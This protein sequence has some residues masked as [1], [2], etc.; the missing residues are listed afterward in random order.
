MNSVA[1]QDK[2]AP[3]V[4]CS[5]LDNFVQIFQLIRPRRPDIRHGEVEIY[6]DSVF[7]TGACGG[8][9]IVHLDF[10]ERYDLS[11]R[12][13]AAREAGRDEVAAKL[14]ENRNRIGI[15]LADVSGHR[16]TDALV[17]AMLHQSFLTGVLYELDRFGEVTTRLFEHL[18]TR[19]SRSLSIEKYITVIYG[20][21]GRTGKFRFLSAG[22]PEPLIFSAEYD[23]LVNISPERLVSFYPLGMFPS[24]DHPDVSRHL[25]ALRYKPSYTVNEV[26]LMAVG[27][28][29]LLATDGLVDHERDDDKPFV[30]TELERILRSV[31]HRTA[32]EIYHAIIDRARSFADPTD[33]MTLVVIKRS[34]QTEE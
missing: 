12:I 33:D 2:E 28:I 26:N 34:G 25:G 18:N 10:D 31:K 14:A 27:D 17:A 3:S 9:H 7:L 16:T 24:E 29:L 30:P 32:Q 23:R 1:K 6:G 19:F 20:E 21:I 5:E 22:S 15:L 8:D 4:C 11:R 13:S